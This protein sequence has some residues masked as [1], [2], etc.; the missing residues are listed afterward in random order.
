MFLDYTIVEQPANL[1]TL[2]LRMTN[3][4]TDF[5]LSHTATDDEPSPAPFFLYY[6]MTH[7]H[8]PVAYHP[9]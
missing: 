2:T 6:P 4:A 8:A 7:V 1:S 5:I 3:Y 9:K